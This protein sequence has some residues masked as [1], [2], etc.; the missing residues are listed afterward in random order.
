MPRPTALPQVA[1]AQRSAWLQGWWAG[2]AVGAVVM[3][4]VCVLAGVLR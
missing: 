4:G 3:L 1:D 2:T